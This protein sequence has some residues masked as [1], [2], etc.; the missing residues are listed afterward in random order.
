LG[1]I[2]LWQLYL[3]ASLLLVALTASNGYVMLFKFHFT[4][5]EPIIERQSVSEP[6][7][8]YNRY[9]AEPIAEHYYLSQSPWAFI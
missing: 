6:G 1:Y 9:E 2:N 8:L 4:A 3:N 7:L 5:K